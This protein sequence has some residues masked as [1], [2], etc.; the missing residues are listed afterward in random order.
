MS[1]KK[2]DIIICGV[3]GQ[4]VILS[5]KVLANAAMLEGLD[6]KASE[7]HGM[8]QRGG[9]VVS[10]VRIGEKV[11]SP[12][13][14]AGQGD[15]IISFEEMEALRYLQLV[16]P[17]ASVILN[18]QKIKP[19]PVILKKAKYPEKISSSL[20][21][22]GFRAVGVNGIKELKEKGFPFR[23][24]NMFLLGIAS[25]NVPVR[26]EN[27]HKAIELSVAG[28]FAA[29]NRDVFAFGRDFKIS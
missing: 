25:R 19:L 3:G 23:S 2:A 29:V 18:L 22:L 21:E 8:A 11:Y 6:V 13:I 14:P 26:E 24:L 27:F 7:V 17:G 16:T 4:G 15:V 1:G 20:A 12:T 5:S 28:K 10:Q 9:A